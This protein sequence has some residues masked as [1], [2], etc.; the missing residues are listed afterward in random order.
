MKGA[1][2]WRVEGKGWIKR[3]QR[4][5]EGSGGERRGGKRRHIY[6]L[7]VQVCRHGTMEYRVRE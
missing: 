4:D 3:E 1:G 2:E 7:L 5:G 6:R